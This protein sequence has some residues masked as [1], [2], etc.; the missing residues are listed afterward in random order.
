MATSS[1][2]NRGYGGGLA[3]RG[4]MSVGGNNGVSPM[5]RGYGGGLAAGAQPGGGFRSNLPG[6]DRGFAGGMTPAQKTP[7]QQAI[8]DINKPLDLSVPDTPATSAPPPMGM[9]WNAQLLPGMGDLP[10]ASSANLPP[11]T[12]GKQPWEAPFGGFRAEG[13]PVMPGR[14]YIVGERGPEV[15]VP[16]MPGVVIPMDAREREMQ[17]RFMTNA[18]HSANV[19]AAEQAWAMRP[20][21]GANSLS[22]RATDGA[23]RSGPLSTRGAVP[24][25]RSMYDPSRIAEQAYRQRRDP[26]LLMQLNQQ[27]TMQNFARERD[28]TNFDQQRQFFDMQQAAQMG[29]YQQQ[30]L[31][32]ADQ[33]NAEQQAQAARDAQQ[34]QQ[35]MTMFGLNQGA[36][37]MDA[38]RKRL[39]E[40]ADRKRVPITGAVQVAPG[41]GISYAD[42]RPMGN[43][44]M[45]KPDAPLPPG[46]V[47]VQAERGGVQYGMPVSKPVVPTVKE[48]KKA[49]GTS[50]YRQWNQNT[51]G[52]EPV[53]F[54]YT[55]NDGIPDNPAGGAAAATAAPGMQTA[56]SGF[57][58][59][60]VQ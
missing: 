50:E 7:Q 36:A 56:K 13:G 41:F 48:F 27:Q 39:Q 34:F 24:V 5:N 60:P 11:S 54:I 21:V 32:R 4:A 59:K 22:S 9:P 42:G 33:W 31:D 45:A 15:I 43:I 14:S 3:G 57:T 23:V 6:M 20:P 37:A 35:Q 38:E 18:Q 17:A 26:R 58:W 46:M 1:I 44:P 19:N 10:P 52:W 2:M 30:R 12:L 53:R 16:Q 55:N 29:Q 49:D 25:G 51:N 28:A 47:P 40:E 8:E